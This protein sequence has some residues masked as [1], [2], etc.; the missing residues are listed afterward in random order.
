MHVLQSEIKIGYP[1]FIFLFCVSGI[2][3]T[4]IPTTKNYALDIPTLGVFARV[5]LAIVQWQG[6]AQEEPPL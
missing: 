2:A 5:S 4:Q 1:I 6:L 3:R